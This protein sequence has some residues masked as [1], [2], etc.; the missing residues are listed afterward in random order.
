MT[1]TKS[2]SGNFSRGGSHTY[3]LTTT[4]SGNAGS[5]GS[6]TVT[7]VLPAGLAPT[8]A[9]GT[10]W[11]CG[12]VTQ[13]V[14]CT[15]SDALAAGGSYPAIAVTVAVSQSAANSVTN[16]VTV[17]GGNEQATRQ[18]Q[19][20]GSHNDRRHLRSADR[21]LAILELWLGRG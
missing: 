21:D 7:D 5:S 17:A 15:R 6:V 14:T 4:N 18:Q 11:A 8:L 12:I 16:T 2:H 19:R 10:G 1:I 13:T 9:S 20:L 3:A